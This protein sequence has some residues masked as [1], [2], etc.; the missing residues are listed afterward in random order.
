MGQRGRLWMIRD[1]SWDSVAEKMEGAYRWALG[2]TERPN[3]VV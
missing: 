1:F 3:F 2:E